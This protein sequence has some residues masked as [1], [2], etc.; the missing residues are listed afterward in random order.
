MGA[1]G[2]TPTGK[3]MLG[4]GQ[5][6]GWVILAKPGDLLIYARQQAL[7]QECALG[8]HVRLLA[9]RGLVTHAG[10][11]RAD[12]DRSLFEYRCRRTELAD[13]TK[14][15]RGTGNLVKPMPAPA[16]QPAGG[17]ARAVLELIA[18]A[19]MAGERCPALPRLAEE[20]G[21]RSAKPVRRILSQLE[22]IGL[23]KLE[24]RRA[25][26]GLPQ[27]VAILPRMGLETAVRMAA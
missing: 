13:P 19:A 11:R 26:D 21:C 3:F 18:D 9:E 24:T 1:G 8:K 14:P 15:M 16:P 7:P 2:N 23:L 5:I 20:I 17:A 10:Q 12:D 4:I 25:P 27:R 22:T 6:D